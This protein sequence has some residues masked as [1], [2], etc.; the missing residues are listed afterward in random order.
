MINVNAAIQNLKPIEV[1]RGPDTAAALAR[2]WQQQAGSDIPALSGAESVMRQFAEHWRKVGKRME[3]P[4]PTLT[5]AA[6]FLEV[7][8]RAMATH[9]AVAD[10]AKRTW[11]TLMDKGADLDGQARNATGQGHSWPNEQEIR[12]VWREMSAEKRGD[13]FRAAVERGD[14]ELVGSILRGNSLTLGTTSERLA[15][16]RATAEQKMAADVIQARDA[17]LAAAA[18]IEQ[19]TAESE[20]LTA[21]AAPNHIYEQIR[22]EHEASQV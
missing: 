11:S 6:N 9:K 4:D 14:Q 16:Y 13:I 1:K 5:P 18:E 7:R 22:A 3:N 19:L 10:N 20:R 8:R 21:L 17:C 15:T 12:S 2:T